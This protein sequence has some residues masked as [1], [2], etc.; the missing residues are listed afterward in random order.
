MTV[1]ELRDKVANHKFSED[2]NNFAVEF[3][4]GRLILKTELK[5]IVH[6]Y[7]YTLEEI[8]NWESYGK[9]PSQLKKVYDHVVTIR[10]KIVSLVKKTNVTE[11]DFNSELS[12]I[13]GL[14]KKEKIDNSH[15]QLSANSPVT[16]FLIDSYK[17]NR[18]AFSTLY[19]YLVNDSSPSNIGGKNN[20]IALV[21]AYRFEQSELGKEYS[22]S[23]SEKRSLGGIKA[24]YGKLVGEATQKTQE[25]INETKKEYDTYVDKLEKLHDEKKED[26]ENLLSKIEV[27]KKE[28]NEEAQNHIN[29]LTETYQEHLRLDGPV[30]HWD[31]RKKHYNFWGKI[32]LG[33]S[34]ILI[35]A[36]A[37]SL[38]LILVSP[39]ELFEIH[40]FAGDPVGIKWTL[41]FITFLSLGAFLI[42]NFTKMAFSAFHLARDAEERA[43]LTHVYLALSKDTEVEKEEKKIAFQS[44]FGRAETGLIGGDSSP[45]L[46]GQLFERITPQ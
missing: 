7:S 35:L 28:N 13:E 42:R 33:I 29:K 40:L 22:G 8:N 46:P 45:T 2:L 16:V 1:N 17:N 3:G 25:Y 38:Y 34:S 14:L 20:F 39:P 30:E 26:I 18:G 32:W 19:N 27:H 36:F 9:L 41:L 43:Q 24:R 15:K 12:N 23:E 44:I 21:E 10:N 5:S 31:K 6:A 37:A 4:D 11:R